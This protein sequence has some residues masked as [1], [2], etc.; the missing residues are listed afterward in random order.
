MWWVFPPLVRYGTKPIVDYF[1]KGPR[2][3]H[4]LAAIGHPLQE[5]N[6]VSYIL[7]GLSADYDPLITLIWPI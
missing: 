4:M 1:S 2:L 3:A 6:A 5:S 7:V